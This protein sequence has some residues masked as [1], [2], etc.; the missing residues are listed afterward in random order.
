MAL[1]LAPLAVGIGTLYANYRRNQKNQEA[2]DILERALQGSQDLS[3][4][5]PP[6]PPELL[7]E[8]GEALITP[9]QADIARALT[10]PTE[11]RNFVLDTVRPRM[12]ENRQRR[13]Q[14]RQLARSNE[15]LMPEN[16]I[17]AQGEALQL[18]EES[19][20][21]LDEELGVVVPVPVTGADDWVD[22]V[23]VL[24]GTAGGLANVLEL[25][26]RVADLAAE[27][28]GTL[29]FIDSGDPRIGQI[30]SQAA[31][32]ILQLR[33]AYKTGQLDEGTERLF[34]SMGLSLGRTNLE[35][36][37]DFIRLLQA[38]PA[39]QQARLRQLAASLNDRL[40]DVR[41]DTRFY[42]GLNPQLLEQADLA[43]ARFDQVASQGVPQGG[44]TAYRGLIESGALGDVLNLGLNL[45]PGID[46]AQQRNILQSLGLTTSPR[47]ESGGQGTTRGRNRGGSR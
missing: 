28:A 29:Q 20:N 31:G 4:E 7:E 38:D 19:F 23:T 36:V 5:G 12:E 11:R 24:D 16:R 17:K 13:A 9:A 1:A 26:Q 27:G 22:N 40:Q 39:S 2:D 30:E 6:V 14:Q 37:G 45:I 42:Q 8:R 15:M 18:G 34:A 25:E 32:L 44:D 21:T 47:R 33:D 43:Q 41:F 3:I 10:D 35:N 46:D